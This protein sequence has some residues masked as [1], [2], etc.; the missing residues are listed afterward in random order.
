MIDY[1]V[2]IVYN[3]LTPDMKQ[4]II[5]LWLKSLVLTIDIAVKRVEEVVCVIKQTSTNKIVG[6]STAYIDMLPVNGHKY[7][8][9]RMFIDK[10]HRGKTIPHKQ[11]WIAATTVATLKENSIGT[12]VKGVVAYLENPRIQ[13]RLMFQ[14]G[15]NKYEDRVFYV[16]FDGS[17]LQNVQEN[18]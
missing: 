5:N 7:F 4:E 10:S 11:P 18:K 13:D 16:N 15:W 12:D 8:F 17:E 6:V 3:K 1:H 9:Y 2:E 14:S